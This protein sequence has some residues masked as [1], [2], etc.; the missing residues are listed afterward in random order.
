MRYRARYGVYIQKEV[1]ILNS[2]VRHWAV[3]LFL[4]MVTFIPHEN[5]VFKVLSN[6]WTGLLRC[7]AL[8]RRISGGFVCAAGVLLFLVL[9]RMAFCLLSCL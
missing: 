2:F 1:F 9:A 4:L 8:D 5:R 7:V 3:A 6:R